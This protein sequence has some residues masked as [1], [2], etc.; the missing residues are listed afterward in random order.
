MIQERA[1]QEQVRTSTSKCQQLRAQLPVLRLERVDPDFGPPVH[2]LPGYK[3]PTGSI[4]D[5]PTLYILERA[6]QSG[7]LVP[8]GT[9]VEVSSGSTAISLAWLCS[10]LRLKLVAV[11]PDNVSEHRKRLIK[12]F[13]GDNADIILTDHALKLRGAAERA[14]S[15]ASELGA[16]QPRQFENEAGVEAFGHVVVPQF[17]DQL[18]PAK[19]VV[20]ACGVGT[21]WT[22]RGLTEGLRARGFA[23]TPTVATPVEEDGTF[24]SRIAG[25]AE[26][27]SKL[28]S[29][30]TVPGLRWVNVRAD[31]ALDRMRWLNANGIP[32]G[33]TGG[34]NFEAVDSVARLYDPRHTVLITVLPDHGN[35][36][37][38]S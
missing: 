1:E 3:C 34:L 6:M 28:I 20:L 36:Y 8:G 17:A 13:G 16:Y 12:H 23:V 10:Q 5:I 7:E 27:A 2:C 31:R 25:V 4:K 22:L 19:R 14:A 15:V 35:R 37:W 30:E 24:S 33:E 38:S 29:P 9:V 21:A 11:M 18:D 26:D 32:A